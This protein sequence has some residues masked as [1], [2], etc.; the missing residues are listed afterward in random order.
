[1]TKDKLSYRLNALCASETFAMDALYNV[2]VKIV[3]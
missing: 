2:T 1:M 3:A